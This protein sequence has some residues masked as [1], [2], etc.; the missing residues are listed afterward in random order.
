MRRKEL[1]MSPRQ[2]EANQRIKDERREQILKA[3]LQ[4]FVRKGLA[5]ARISDIAAAADLS[6]GLVYHYFRD[7]E[8]LFVELV[9]RA[10]SGGVQVT[11][12]ALDAQGSPLE[13][14]HALCEEMVEGIR[15]DPEYTLLVV[16]AITQESLPEAAHEAVARLSEQTYENVTKLIRQCQAAGQVVGGDPRELTELYF[17]VIQGLALSRSATP[18][19]AQE[20]M[21]QQEVFP[22]AGAVMRLFQAHEQNRENDD[23]N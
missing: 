1:A 2:E 4:I 18:L 3:A 13:R 17:A 20:G 5:A 14:L 8:D 11:Q 9:R 12:A 19:R 22:S 23:D 7:K 16:Q 6:Y 10:V 15:D 21:R